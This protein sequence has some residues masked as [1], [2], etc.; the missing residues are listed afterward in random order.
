[1]DYYYVFW[2]R[3]ILRPILNYLITPDVYFNLIKEPKDLNDSIITIIYTLNDREVPASNSIRLK[4][5][6]KN[7]QFVEYTDHNHI[8]LF[9]DHQIWDDNYNE[10]NHGKRDI[11]VNIKEISEISKMLRL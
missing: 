4:N 11:S 8:N 10:I 2:A 6:L 9:I 7:A 5:V 3:L 1:M